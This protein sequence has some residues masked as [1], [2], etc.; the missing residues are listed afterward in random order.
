MI[1]DDSI[2]TA[3]IVSGLTTRRSVIIAS[4]RVRLILADTPDNFSF[5]YF[6]YLKLDLLDTVQTR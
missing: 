4:A 3:E 5:I 6:Y 2:I 1:Y